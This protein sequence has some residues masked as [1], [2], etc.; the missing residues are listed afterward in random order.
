M[1]N[2]YDVVMA[3]LV[4]FRSGDPCYNMRFNHNQ[5]ISSQTASYAHF[6]N[7]FGGFNDDAHNRN[8]YVKSVCLKW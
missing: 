2:I 4:K 3:D 6:F 5:Y 7:L 8:G 1:L